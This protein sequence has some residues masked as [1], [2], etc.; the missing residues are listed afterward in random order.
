MQEAK[1]LWESRNSSKPGNDSSKNN[2][3]EETSS[4]YL[5]MD[6]KPKEVVV[7]H[8]DPE[9]Y[10]S[11]LWPAICLFGASFGAFRLISWNAEF[12]TLVE[13]WLWR[14]AALTSIISMMIFIHFRKVI[15]RWGGPLTIISLLSPAFY[16]LSRIIMLGGDCGI[17]G[18]QPCN[19]SDLCCLDI[20][21]PFPVTAVKIICIT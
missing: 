8:W 10:R 7:A 21:D 1:A 4:D 2:E 17:Q 16:R 3:K 20:L 18:L 6:L 19:L 9:L 12:S 5:S 11:R 13:Q 15:C 14:A